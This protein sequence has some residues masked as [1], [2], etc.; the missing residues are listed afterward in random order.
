MKDFHGIIFAYSAAPELRELV[1]VRTA[2]SLPFCGRYRLIDFALSSL[3]NA[4]VL[5]C[6]VIMQRDYQSLLDHI[7]S[8]KA[9][10][11][12]RR[13]GGL[14]M[15]PPFGMPA[16]HS[17][18]YNGTIE[19]LNAVSSYIRD[20]PDKYMI[21]MLGNLCANID[22]GPAMEQHMKSG[23]QITAIC[24]DHKG[25]GARYGYVADESGK[26]TQILY[27]VE[28]EKALPSLET[29]IINRDVL[30]EMM[31]KCQAKG[32]YRFHRDALHSFLAYGGVMDTYIHPGYAKCIRSLDD[33]YKANMDML[34]MACRRQ[35]FPAARPVRTKAHE[36]VSTYY[37]EAAVAKNCLVADNCKIEGDIENCIVFSG[38]RIEKGAKLR[39]C[40]LMRGANVAEGAELNYVIADKHCSFSQGTVLTGNE[41]LPV[42]VP[43]GSHI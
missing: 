20:L 6:G 23:A 30:L 28:Q 42:I 9:W 21:L 29:Y 15:L 37:A 24:S 31:D 10:D 33:Y 35:L 14:R 40:I 18:N 39:N 36:E 22:L 26:V 38:A 13:V 41:K 5:D 16:Y 34:D 1:D 4:G 27:G 8:G 25:S 12:S 2:A 11:M 7:G 43:K 3:R 32:L 19:A 17:G